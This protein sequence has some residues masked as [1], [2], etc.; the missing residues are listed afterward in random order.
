LVTLTM[1]KETTNALNAIGE[2]IF[3]ADSNFNIVWINKFADGLIKKLGK[4]LPIQSSE[5]LIGKNIDMFHRT[6]SKQKGILTGELPHITKINLFEKYTA[7]IVV[8]SFELS[9]GDIGYILTWKD[10]TE[11]EKDKQLIDMLSTTVIET[12]IEGVL[13]VPVTGTLSVERIE[14]MTATILKEAHDKIASNILIDFTGMSGNINSAVAYQLD[15]LSKS[16][17]LIG[18]NVV[19]V[20]FPVEVVRTIVTSGIQLK[21]KTYGNFKQAITAIFKDKGYT[22]KQHGVPV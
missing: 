13:L 12:T 22:L 2:N 11:Y 16:L 18:V 9:N 21:V 15:I 10:V 17:S 1:N 5:D 8:D 4:F 7:S 14:K 3:I 6:P 20:G 19:F